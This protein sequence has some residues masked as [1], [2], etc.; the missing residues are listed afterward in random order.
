MDVK[1]AAKEIKRLL[2]KRQKEIMLSFVEEG[3]IYTMKDMSGNLSTNIPSV[4]KIIKKFEIPFDSDGM[5]SIMAKGDIDAKNNLLES[6][7]LSGELSTNMGS[8]VHYELE[9]EAL[10]R[11]GIKKE[12]RQPIFE[13]NDEQKKISDKMIEGGKKFLDLMTERGAVLIDTETLLG[14]PILGYTGQP[15][16]LWAIPNKSNTEV[17]I[18]ITDWKS[19]KK[20]N[21]E[22]Q[23]Y[24]KNLKPPFGNYPSTAL[25]KYYLQL[26]LYGKLIIEMLK[27]TKYESAK[28]L[29]NIIVLLKDNGTF[30]EYR[31]P[32]AINDG[33][34]EMDLSKY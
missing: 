1:K 19:N 9:I 17:G 27:G 4:S 8:R 3:H 30:E 24:T 32:K 11:Y 12:V 28:I 26:P 6:W 34:L 15:D 18:L 16:K 7:R 14:D 2:E 29:G 5:S 20:K 23:R 13:I 21:F 22:V 33:I 31:V 10:S 25:G